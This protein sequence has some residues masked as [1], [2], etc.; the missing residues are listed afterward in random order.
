M[1]TERKRTIATVLDD[2]FPI[3]E[4][5]GAELMDSLKTIIEA[6]TEDIEFTKVSNE[7]LVL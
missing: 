6:P 3:L 2:N 5:K 4:T 1:V 7:I